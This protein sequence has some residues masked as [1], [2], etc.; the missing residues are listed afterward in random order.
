MPIWARVLQPRHLSLFDH[1]FEYLLISQRIH[2]TPES[3][4]FISDEFLSLDQPIKRLQDQF[5]AVT[6]IIKNFLAEDEVPTI[7]PSLRFRVR[8]KSPYHPI[9]VKF[10]QMEIEWRAH[11]N[12]TPDLAAVLEK[13][14]HVRQSHISQAVA[15]VCKKYPLA[16]HELPDGGQSLANVAPNAG[17]D[18]VYAPIRGTI[19]KNF[20]L[21]AEFRNN[22]I[23]VHRRSVV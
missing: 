13:V 5:L 6:Y 20:N 23:A 8:T 9:L 19:A 14:D 12:E 1:L 18:Q 15:I 21:A 11:G 22:T 4:I 16:F 7:D 3:L 10:G 2:R 17:I